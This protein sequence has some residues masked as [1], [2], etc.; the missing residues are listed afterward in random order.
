M[1]KQAG[2]LFN[3]PITQLQYCDGGLILTTLSFTKCSFLWYYTTPSRLWT[4]YVT[5]TGDLEW[6]ESVQQG[7]TLLVTVSEQHTD[8]SEGNVCSARDPGYNLLA[9]SRCI[10]STFTFYDSA[11]WVTHNS[12]YEM[13]FTMLPRPQT[14]VGW[15]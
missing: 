3:V 12:I 2:C 9:S 7:K 5:L 4:A 14:L 10:L 15:F 1:L 11:Y 13:F 8:T 6:W